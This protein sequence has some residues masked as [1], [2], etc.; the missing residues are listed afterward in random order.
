I[1]SHSLVSNESNGRRYCASVSSGCRALG[2]HVMDVG[3]WTEIAHIDD[4]PGAAEGASGD[5]APM[6]TP[7]GPGQACVINGVVVDPSCANNPRYAENVRHA[8]ETVH[9]TGVS[10]LNGIGGGAA[11][12]GTRLSQH[13]DPQA[14]ST[15]ICCGRCTN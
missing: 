13:L 10:C 1:I 6:V 7:I 9:Q 5:G 4:M 11:E 15:Q 14:P 3:T 2:G 12:A 8:I